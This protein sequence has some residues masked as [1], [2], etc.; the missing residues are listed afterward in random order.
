VRYTEIEERGLLRFTRSYTDGEVVGVAITTRNGR[1]LM[2]LQRI[3]DGWRAALR[4]KRG[5]I[6]HA[7]PLDLVDCTMTQAAELAMAVSYYGEC[8]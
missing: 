2:D 6:I 1:W 3:P 4:A 8:P 5:G 7:Q